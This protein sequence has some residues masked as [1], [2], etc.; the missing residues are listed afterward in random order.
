MANICKTTNKN[1]KRQTNAY[2]P[3]IG[4]GRVGL[5]ALPRPPSEVAGQAQ[6][7]EAQVGPL[8]DAPQG[9]LDP[10]VLGQMA[11]HAADS[12]TLG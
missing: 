9:H 2:V 5:E 7:D 3:E 12:R 8:V 1:S 11:G 4:H 10:A 6:P